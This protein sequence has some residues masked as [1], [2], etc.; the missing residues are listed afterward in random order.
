VLLLEAGELNAELTHRVAAGARYTFWNTDDGSKYN[1]RYKSVPE[2]ELA[3]RELV[4]DRGHGLGGSTSIN[5]G[6][7]DYGRKEEMEEWGRLVDDDA[8]T[9]N[10]LLTRMKKVGVKTVSRLC[11]LQIL[12]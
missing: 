6:L 12:S 11:G 8:W 10:G 9:W 2:P 7:W 5:I 3:G 4:Y 1:Y